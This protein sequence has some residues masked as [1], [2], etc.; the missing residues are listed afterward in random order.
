[1][2]IDI[3]VWG[4]GVST[5]DIRGRNGLHARNWILSTPVVGE[6][7]DMWLAVD[8]MRLPRRSNASAGIGLEKEL[9]ADEPR[10]GYYAAPS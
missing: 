3:A 1:M 2:D 5:V 7:V 9:T 4:L 6:L 8:V 10:A